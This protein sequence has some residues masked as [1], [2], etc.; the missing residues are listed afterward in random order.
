VRQNVKSPKADGEYYF[1]LAGF[2]CKNTRGST[3]IDGSVGY[4]VP[5]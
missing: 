4:V 3:G 1:D 5:G 2:I